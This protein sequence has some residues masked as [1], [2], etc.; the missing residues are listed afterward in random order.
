MND[1]VKLLFLNQY[2]QH[3]KESVSLFINILNEMIV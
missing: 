1:V 2:V 3:P